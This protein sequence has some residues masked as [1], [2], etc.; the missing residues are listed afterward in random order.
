MRCQHFGVNFAYLLYMPSQ[1]VFVAVGG[2]ED[3]LNGGPET[4][5]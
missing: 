2:A 1:H 4:F 3:A 5:T